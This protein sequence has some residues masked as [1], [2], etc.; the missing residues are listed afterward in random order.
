MMII[1]KYKGDQ[2]SQD[3]VSVVG[4]GVVFDSGGVNLKPGS[5]MDDMHLDKTGACSA[6][7][8]FKYSV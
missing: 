1:M 6:I 2:N 4:K 3:Y 5:A 8:V 7:S